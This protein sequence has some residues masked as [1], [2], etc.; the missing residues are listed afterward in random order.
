MYNFDFIDLANE[1]A[2]QVS[3]RRKMKR[4]RLQVIVWTAWIVF[5]VLCQYG[6]IL[7]NGEW[8]LGG[9]VLGPVIALMLVII[10]LYVKG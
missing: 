9:N 10:N 4:I 8:I 2:R 1:N 5:T 7:Q 6:A 3:K